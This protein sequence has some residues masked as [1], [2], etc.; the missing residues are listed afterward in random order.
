MYQP[1]TKASE[2][3]TMSPSNE[4]WSDEYMVF[5]GRATFR[6]GNQRFRHVFAVAG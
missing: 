3:M 4:P 2:T 6:S 5:G 1:T